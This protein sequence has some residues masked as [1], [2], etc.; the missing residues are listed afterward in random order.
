M[1][2]TMADAPSHQN[3]VFIGDLLS[4]GSSSDLVE[5]VLGQGTFGTVAECMNI[6]DK[7][8]VAIKMMRNHGYLVMQATA[9][10][11][12]DGLLLWVKLI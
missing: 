12:Y 4:S 3:R 5:S 9:D 1:A 7:K 6:T 10:K 8:T 11:Q 2:L